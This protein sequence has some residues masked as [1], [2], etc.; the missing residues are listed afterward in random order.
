M[1]IF[2]AVSALVEVKYAKGRVYSVHT[3]AV[4]FLVLQKTTAA[5]VELDLHWPLQWFAAFVG[6]GILQ[7]VELV[8][9]VPFVVFVSS[10][11]V[12][13]EHLFSIFQ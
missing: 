13:S 12:S 8:A 9:A 7:S 6:P 2:V 3:A 10:P 4:E 1:A 5:F 11:A